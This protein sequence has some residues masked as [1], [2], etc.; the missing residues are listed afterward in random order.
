MRKDEIPAPLLPLFLTVEAVRHRARRVAEA[1]DLGG[2]S[3]ELALLIGVLI[4]AAGAV[5]LAVTD[6]IGNDVKGI[7]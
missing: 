2:L 6:V 1:E 7:H 4:V 3:I 5:V